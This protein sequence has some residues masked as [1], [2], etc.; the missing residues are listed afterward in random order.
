MSKQK[1][2]SGKTIYDWIMDEVYTEAMYSNLDTDSE[3]DMSQIIKGLRDAAN[4]LEKPFKQVK[5]KG[6]AMAEDY[7]PNDPANW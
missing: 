4:E 5:A 3:E 2:S 6:Q 7:N 1:S